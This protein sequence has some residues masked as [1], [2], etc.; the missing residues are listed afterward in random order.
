VGTHQPL[1][2]LRQLFQDK[3]VHNGMG[4]IQQI[5][6][7][8]TRQTCRVLVNM[9]PNIDGIGPA[10]QLVC[11]L[12]WKFIDNEAGIFMLPNVNDLALVKII[13]G[14]EEQAYVTDYCSTTEELLPIDCLD[15]SLVV[16]AR[17]GKPLRLL[18]D[19]AIYVQKGKFGA[20]PNANAASPFVLG[21]V[22]ATFQT[23]LI[24]AFTNASQIGICG[25]GSV[26]L[27][28]GLAQTLTQL[29]STF[30]TTVST[31]FLSAIFFSERGS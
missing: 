11:K 12:A 24:Q 31:N 30:I 20:A 26:Q 25:V 13:D 28:P 6:I 14:D 23:Q 15:G 5:E 7:S 9:F 22:M 18:S 4:L 16:K 10:N 2:E 3:R 21:D 17:S 19:T 8:P 27:D 1:E 29:I